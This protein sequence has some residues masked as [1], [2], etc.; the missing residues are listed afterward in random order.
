M[1]AYAK[2]GPFTTAQPPAVDSTFLNKIE[3]A[4]VRG[5][6]LR[7]TQ[8]ARVDS[9]AVANPDALYVVDSG[10]AI[11]ELAISNGV[12]WVVAVGSG[13]GG[14][15]AWKGAWAPATVYAV[16][17][18]VTYNGSTYRATIAHTSGATFLTGD[19]GWQVVALAGSVRS[20]DTVPAC[21]LTHSVTQAPTSGSPLAFN[22]VLTDTD[23]MTVVA[24]KV[25]IKT[26]GI[27]QVSAFVEASATNT[28][29]ANDWRLVPRKNG[30]NIADMPIAPNDYSSAWSRPI[31]CAAGDVL[32]LA[33][34]SSGTSNW[35]ALG[36]ERGL[37]FSVVWNGGP[38]TTTTE[39][40]TPSVKATS[41]TTVA[42]SGANPTV[43]AFATEQHDTAQMH[44]TAVN[45]NRLTCPTPGVYSIKANVVPQVT[46]PGAYKVQ[47]RLNGVT[48]IAEGSPDSNTIGGYNSTSI[49]VP[50]LKLAA[51]DYVEILV[52]NSNA[53]GFGATTTASMTMLATGKTV[54]PRARAL[55][56]AA[57]SHPNATWQKIPLDALDRGMDNDAI[58]DAANNRF[59]IKTAGTYTIAGGTIWDVSGSGS[60]RLL[61]IYLNGASQAQGPGFPISAIAQARTNVATTLDLA[62]NDVIELYAYQDSGSAR[63]V[64]TG[65]P[66]G[67]WMSLV[68]VGQSGAGSNNDPGL[69]QSGTDLY[70]TNSGKLRI[71]GSAGAIAVAA[72]AEE[73]RMVRG[74]VNADGSIAKGAGF[75]VART[76]TGKYT[77]TFTNGTFSAEPAV[78]LAIYANG[79]NAGNLITLSDT[80]GGKD[81]TKF[82]VFCLNPGSTTF[83]DSKFEFTA[84]GPR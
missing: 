34:V 6:H 43:L 40:G 52:T 63:P 4:L 58:F 35:S 5:A 7:G 53:G 2:S 12:T 31:K 22:T 45:T 84:I 75:T 51:G 17:D 37:L 23:G 1:S 19:G 50:D 44:D 82:G 27:Y 47:A 36:G 69:A 70:T 41:T 18:L 80:A 62:V 26:P 48:T 42:G 46:P 77:I 29:S 14:S 32:D 21:I 76:A 24:N 57:W 39:V 25:T 10:T 65:Q 66:D 81:A 78:S 56:N 55:R 38:G 79:T 74:I 73:L 3:D 9:L 16:N 59:V 71:G 68:K 33:F 61:S 11:G 54:I 30:T 28:T 13:S 72:P 20:N 15:S 49:A 67:T 83:I 8:L 64:I 60:Y